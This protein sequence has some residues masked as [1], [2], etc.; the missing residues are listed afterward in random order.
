MLLLRARVDLGAME[1]KGC[2][3]FPKAPAS[4]E[5]QHQISS[6]HIKDTRCWESYPSAKKQSVYSTAQPTGQNILVYDKNFIGL[7]DPSAELKIHRQLRGKTTIK[8]WNT[9]DVTLNWIWW[10]GFDSVDLRNM[11]HLIIVITPRRSLSRRGST[12]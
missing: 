10:W 12:C 9:V 4:L 2:S 8:M 11:E 5:P 3:E 1:M 7:N 6:C